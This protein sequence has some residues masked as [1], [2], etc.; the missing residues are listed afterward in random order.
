MSIKPAT[1]K[2]RESTIQKL[3]EMQEKINEKANAKMTKSELL[4]YLIRE[5]AKKGIGKEMRLY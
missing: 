5:A 3:E 1:F 4:D 2:L